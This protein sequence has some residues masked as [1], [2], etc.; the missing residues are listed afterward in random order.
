LTRCH[1]RLGLGRQHERRGERVGVLLDQQRDH[2]HVGQRRRRADRHDSAVLGDVGAGDRDLVRRRG[3]VAAEALGDACD[4]LGLERGLVPFGL[5]RACFLRRDHAGGDEQTQ[6]AVATGGFQRLASI[7]AH[8]DLLLL[9]ARHLDGAPAKTCGAE[10][11]TVLSPA[12]GP[13][14]H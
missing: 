8:L 7:H 9:K 4:V 13:E 6:H 1:E 10:P 3:G 14:D 5:L 11:G 12:A 2:L